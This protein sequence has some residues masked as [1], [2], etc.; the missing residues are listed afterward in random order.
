MTQK[1]RIV[2]KKY[3]IKRIFLKL[4]ET[5]SQIK[6]LKLIYDFDFCELKEN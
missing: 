1:I 5:S 2:M 3:E 4:T 6:T